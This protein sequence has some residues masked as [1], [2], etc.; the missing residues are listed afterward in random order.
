MAGGVNGDESICAEPGDV[1]ICAEPGDEGK[2]AEPGDEGICAELGNEDKCAEPGDE[3]VCAEPGD[4]GICAELMPK[5]LNKNDCWR[6]KT[7]SKH[8]KGLKERYLF[9]QD[10]TCT[11][12]G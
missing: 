4:E 12:S 3:G 5:I 10:T 1:G 11:F 2:C 7:R 8:I 6:S 9:G